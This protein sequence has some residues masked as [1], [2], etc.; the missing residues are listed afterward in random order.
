[1]LL[2]SKAYGKYI[3]KV[4]EVYESALCNVDAYWLHSQF[5]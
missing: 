4:S 1:M 5:S 3:Y 2:R